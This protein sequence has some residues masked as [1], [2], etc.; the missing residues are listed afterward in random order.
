M[1][2]REPNLMDFLSQL[3]RLEMEGKPTRR[4][5]EEVWERIKE[6]I[7]EKVD[8]EREENARNPNRR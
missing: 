2:E 7:E 4:L 8:K 3:Q 1:G 6:Q 5:Q